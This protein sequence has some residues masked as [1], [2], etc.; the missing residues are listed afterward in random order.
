MMIGCLVPVAGGLQGI[1]FGAGM[2]GHPADI[3]LDSHVRYLS[4]LL[5]GIA[6]GFASAIPTIEKMGYRV[7]LLSAIVVTGGLARLYGMFVDGLPK[8]VMI[9]ALVMEL[10]VVPTLWLLQKRVARQWM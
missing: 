3:T 9:F 1:A 7:G 2:S 6:F 8:P 10:G 5:F 4:G